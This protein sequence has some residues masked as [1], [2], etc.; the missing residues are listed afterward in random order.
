M[1][2]LGDFVETAI[3]ESKTLKYCIRLPLVSQLA[4]A[5]HIPTA[6]ARSDETPAYFDSSSQALN[7]EAFPF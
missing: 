3:R 2:T 5:F 7:N 4:A 6:A 1:G